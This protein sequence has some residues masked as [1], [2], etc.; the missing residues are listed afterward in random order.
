MGLDITDGTISLPHQKN[1]TIILP[2]GEAVVLGIKICGFSQIS[3]LPSIQYW[4]PGIAAA[5]EPLIVVYPKT[6][7]DIVTRAAAVCLV[8]GL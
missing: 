3:E 1:G 6:F 7:P 2:N 8:M 5:G 4:H